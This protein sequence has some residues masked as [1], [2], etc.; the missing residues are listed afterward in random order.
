MM[1][2][3]MM[4][5]INNNGLYKKSELKFTRHARLREPTAVSVHRLSWSISIHFIAILSS[6][7]ENHKKYY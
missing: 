2:M 7:A 4:M 1:M 5:M 6:A 3:M